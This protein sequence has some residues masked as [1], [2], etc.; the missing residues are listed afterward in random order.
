MPKQPNLFHSQ[1]NTLPKDVAAKFYISAAFG[2]SFM[3]RSVA[4]TRLSTFYA[5]LITK[6]GNRNL[7]KDVPDA[8]GMKSHSIKLKKKS[9]MENKS[10]MCGECKEK[11][12]LTS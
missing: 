6:I 10:D 3:T 12:H 1:P 11:N 4:H 5:Y 8:D 2:L 9:C 7:N